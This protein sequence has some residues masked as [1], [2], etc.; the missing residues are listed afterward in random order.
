MSSA[1]S[2]TV[3]R[4]TALVVVAVLVAY[5]MF[6]T[7]LWAAPTSVINEKASPVT[8]R[9]MYPLFSQNWQ[10]FAP[11]PQS[12]DLRVWVRATTREDGTETVTEWANLGDIFNDQVRHQILPTRTWRMP[13]SVNRFYTTSYGSLE[14]Q[15]QAVVHSDHV[16]TDGTGRKSLADDLLGTGM[17]VSGMESYLRSEE[18]LYEFG[19]L[20][21]MDLWPDTEIVAVQMSTSTQGLVPFEERLTP[22]DRKS[23]V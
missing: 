15:Q 22:G 8:S 23:V 19:T 10:I 20:A 9:H 2:R 11:D 6:A 13:V 17:S 7:F 12:V 4:R 3:V 16:S 18:S 14:G 1:G 21:A 5:H